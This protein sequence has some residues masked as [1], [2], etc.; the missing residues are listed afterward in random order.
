LVFN[1]KGDYDRTGTYSVNYIRYIRHL[2]DENQHV[3]FVGD[4]TFF[5]QP[6]GEILCSQANEALLACPYVNYSLSRH[7]RDENGF[8]RFF[9][10]ELAY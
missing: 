1:G 6:R 3:R 7:L 4:E 5:R 10:N 9:K 8:D 2:D